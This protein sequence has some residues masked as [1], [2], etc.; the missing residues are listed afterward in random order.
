MSLFLGIDLGTSAVKALL[1]DERQTVRATAEAPLATRHPGPLASEQDPHAWWD[2]LLAAVSQAGGLDDVDAIEAAALNRTGLARVLGVPAMAGL[3]APKLLW[4]ARHE[5]GVI[6]RAR[7]R[8]RWRAPSECSGG[9]GPPSPSAIA[10]MT[11][12]SAV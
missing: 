8:W 4:L 10:S 11:S 5:S 12:R 6:A 9:V 2:A 3:T 1:V 7:S